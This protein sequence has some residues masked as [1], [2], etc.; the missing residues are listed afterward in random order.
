M[1][2]Y[3]VATL[4][5]NG[6][7][8]TNWNQYDSLADIDFE[9]VAEFAK[10][11]YGYYYGTKSRSLTSARS[12]TVLYLA[13]DVVEQLKEKQEEF[14]KKHNHNMVKEVDK[15]LKELEAIS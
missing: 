14:A 6:Y 10:L 1:K 11:G 15:T 12:R 13:E 4:S 9:K 8:V 5:P 2:T 3:S 7:W